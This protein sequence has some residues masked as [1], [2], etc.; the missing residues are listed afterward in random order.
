VTTPSDQP[1]VFPDQIK[2]GDRFQAAGLEYQA[3]SVTI[4]RDGVWPV[5]KV[6]AVRPDGTG[7]LVVRFSGDDW[8]S[9]TKRIPDDW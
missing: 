8:V 2:A 9:L 3:I 5:I 4:N 7:H 6:E 1:L